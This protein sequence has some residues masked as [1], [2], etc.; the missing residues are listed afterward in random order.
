MNSSG[1]GDFLVILM[2]MGIA[3]IAGFFLWRGYR[4]GPRGTGEPVGRIER[5]SR[6]TERKMARSAR[7]FRADEASVVYN[8][9][10]LRTGPRSALSVVLDDGTLLEIGANSLLVVDRSFGTDLALAAGTVRV[11]LKNSNNAVRLRMGE[12]QAILTGGSLRVE[13]T[14]GRSR[15]V[16]E[17]GSARYEPLPPPPKAAAPGSTAATPE[18]SSPALPGAGSPAPLPAAPI[19]LEAGQLFD[20]ERGDQR[21]ISED[22][23]DFFAP[24]LVKTAPSAPRLLSPVDARLSRSVFP[25]AL[26]LEWTRVDVA[27]RYRVRVLESS[28]GS[29]IADRLVTQTSLLVELPSPGSYSWEVS[30][31][32]GDGDAGISDR[33]DA[34][35][36]AY[37]EPARFTL[38]TLQVTA[39]LLSLVATAPG[40][41]LGGVPLL[42]WDRPQG[43]RSWELEL[44]ET[45]AADSPPL[46]HTLTQP[47]F[48]ADASMVGKGWRALLRSVMPDGS[49]SAPADLVFSIPDWRPLT[50]R[51]PLAGALVQ[52]GVSFS[53]DDPNGGSRY[54]FELSAH[55][56]FRD[57]VV[58][59]TLGARSID[60]SIGSQEPGNLY[61]RAL[62]LDGEGAV[63][64]TTA[65][66][67]IVK[68]ALLAVPRLREPL[69]DASFD[70]VTIGSLTFSWDPVPGASE[71]EVR[72]FERVGSQDR[73][74]R[75]IRVTDP[76]WELD[77][78]AGFSFDRFQ[79]E[80]SAIQGEGDTPVARS[81][82]G[83]SWFRFEQTETLA[84]PK[85]TVMKKKGVY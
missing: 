80:V 65:V 27:Q 8:R 42:R 31:L 47:F 71:Y 59:R 44:F 73:V 24:V 50:V 3:S 56:D 23:D 60:L 12:G 34:L 68:P 2:L 52:Q 70:P 48:M 81:T 38:E 14:A 6:T 74:L 54:R 25:T 15:M 57:P 40:A 64:A 1:R 72:V 55:D 41:L 30:A 83:R 22:E 63:R 33:D 7:W 51:S 36:S 43:V 20:S 76:V 66:S 16:L 82:S 37:T 13:E 5:V 69:R 26:P 46:R 28:S 11:S 58:S 67:T 62:L 75:Q 19:P 85:I 21:P 18:T 39:P 79:W 49:R 4:E 10:T 29:L 35:A 17:E 78:F 61:W 32:G 53:W 77:D 9:D 45:E 84:V